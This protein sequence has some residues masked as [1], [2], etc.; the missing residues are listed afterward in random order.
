MVHTIQ[1]R[2]GLFVQ[3]VM[4]M[5]KKTENVSGVKVVLTVVKKTIRGFRLFET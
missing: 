3:L 4:E 5:K 2:K 1:K